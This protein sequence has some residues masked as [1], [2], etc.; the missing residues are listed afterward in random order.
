M[1]SKLSKLAIVFT[2][3]ISTALHAEVLPNELSQLFEADS[4]TVNWMGTSDSG[5]ECS[6][7]MYRDGDGQDERLDVFGLSGTSFVA[8][9][10][11]DRMPLQKYSATPVRISAV[12]GN[13]VGRNKRKNVLDIEL[14]PSGEVRNVIL[15][16]YIYRAEVKGFERTEFMIC[17]INDF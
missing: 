13:G 9:V 8:Y 4:N 15:A 10:Q 1:I 6:I 5:E 3:L 14:M 2:V 12:T 7:N 11:N 16:E 17:K